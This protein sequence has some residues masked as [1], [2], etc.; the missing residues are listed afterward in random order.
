MKSLKG[1]HHFIWGRQQRSITIHRVIVMPQPLG[2]FFAYVLDQIGQ[3]KLPEKEMLRTYACLDVGWNTTDLSAIK[4][5]TPADQW[6]GGTQ[7]GVRNVIQIVGDEI[8]RAYGLDLK[9]HEVEQ[10]IRERRVE[11]FG[12]YHDIGDIIDSATEVLAQQVVSSATELWSDGRRM[13]RILIFGGGGGFFGPA[14]R[15]AFPLNSVQLP[16]PALANA[17][18][19]CY[20]AQRDIF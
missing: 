3:A 12:Q 10:A 15:A 19:F 8:L 16:K 6:Q 5:L 17:I 7:V 11:V 2:G 1:E 13:S 9:P 18:G 14:I 4:N 20:Y